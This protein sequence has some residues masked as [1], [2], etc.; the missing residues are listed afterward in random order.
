MFIDRQI[1][2]DKIIN[3][4]LSGNLKG[5]EKLFDELNESYQ[6]D[7]LNSETLNSISAFLDFP[8]D[9]KVEICIH[10]DSIVLRYETPYYY[11]GKTIKGQRLIFFWDMDGIKY[12]RFLL[13]YL[14]CQIKKCEDCLRNEK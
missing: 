3:R 12:L 4:L 7:E 2:V 9:K 14:N 13:I 8:I 10:E 1:K 6:L 11:E 5:I